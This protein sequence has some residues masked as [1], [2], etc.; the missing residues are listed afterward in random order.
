MFA[1]NVELEPFLFENRSR[2]QCSVFW[3]SQT[4]LVYFDGSLKGSLTAP[5]TPFVE[6]KHGGGC[7]LLSWEYQIC[8]CK[9]H[10]W[11]NTQAPRL[12]LFRCEVD[13]TRSLPKRPIR[14]P[15]TALAGRASL[16]TVSSQQLC[17][18]WSVLC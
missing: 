12:N 13:P 6:Q 9:E 16:N 15:R 4:G 14:V 11:N 1:G 3:M 17:F 7:R 18:H 10:D 8:I 2:W 5:L